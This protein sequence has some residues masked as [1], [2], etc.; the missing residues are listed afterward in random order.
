MGPSAGDRKLG[1]EAQLLL[2]RI[3]QRLGTVP[4]GLSASWKES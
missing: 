1:R 4:N 3:L 2:D